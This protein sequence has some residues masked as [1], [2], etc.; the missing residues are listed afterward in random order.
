M[1]SGKDGLAFI[2]G[3]VLVQPLEPGELDPPLP[4]DHNRFLRQQKHIAAAQAAPALASR[5][6]LELPAKIAQLLD[7]LGYSGLLAALDG[8]VAEG[9]QLEQFVFE[10]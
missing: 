9:R 4:P 10:F 3:V 5:P 1:F 7:N 8:L 6:L 2:D